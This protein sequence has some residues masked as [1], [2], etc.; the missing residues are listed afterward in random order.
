MIDLTNPACVLR[1]SGVVDLIYNHSY[2]A[3]LQI[4]IYWCVKPS[5]AGKG[6]HEVVDEEIICRFTVWFHNLLHSG[7][8]F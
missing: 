1:A 8:P 6:D 7:N 2:S 4:L 3:K 5:P